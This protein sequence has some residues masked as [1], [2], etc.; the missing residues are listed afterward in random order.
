MRRFHHPTEQLKS[1]SDADTIAAWR[2]VEPAG[3]SG[4]DAEGEE[5]ALA[6][7]LR[8]GYGR[9][10]NASLTRLAAAAVE[11]NGPLQAR[12]SRS[13]FRI[14]RAGPETSDQYVGRS[15]GGQTVARSA[16]KIV[17]WEEDALVGM[18]SI[19]DSSSK[20]MP[21]ELPDGP[22][23]PQAVLPREDPKGRCWCQC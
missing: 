5:G 4:D 21:A 14:R 17:R 15:T 8:W 7:R 23:L 9:Q 2:R 10:R 18:T 6:G 19:C 3:P 22:R 13:G 16:G 12:W 11:V 20:G 1:L